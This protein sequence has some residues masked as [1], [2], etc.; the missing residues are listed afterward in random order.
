MKQHLLSLTEHVYRESHLKCSWNIFRKIF[1]TY[2]LRNSSPVS[3]KIMCKEFVIVYGHES[4]KE[5][6]INSRSVIMNHIYCAACNICMYNM[7]KIH[8]FVSLMDRIIWITRYI[9]GR[10]TQICDLRFYE[11]LKVLVYFKLFMTACQ[12]WI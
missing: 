3:R 4:T 10:H 1:K 9:L 8:I 7:C 11:V 2:F 5:F 12:N 6:R